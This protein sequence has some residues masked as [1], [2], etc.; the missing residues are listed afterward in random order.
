[1]TPGDLPALNVG[2][3]QQLLRRAKFR[4]GSRSR[5]CRRA[6]R[7]WIRRSAP[8]SS[9]DFTLP[10]QRRGRRCFAAARRRADRDQRPHQ[11]RGRAVHLRVKDLARYRATYDATVIR[12]LRAAGAIP[13]GRLNMDEFAMGSST[14]NSAFGPTRNPWDTTRIPGGSSGGSAAAVAA[15]EASPR[16]DRTPADRSGNRRRSADV[17]D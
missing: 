8:I 4:R 14:E 10:S 15:D 7:R 11:R 6:S 13:F 12:K 3:L 2:E 5:R 16:S 17:S 1:M 9:L